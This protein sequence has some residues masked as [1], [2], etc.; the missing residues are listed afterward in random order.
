MPQAVEA[1]FRQSSASAQD[2]VVVI[3]DSGPLVA[4]VEV[5][6]TE[7]VADGVHTLHI[8]GHSEEMGAIK[9][10]SGHC[11]GFKDAQ[12]S[13]SSHATTLVDVVVGIVVGVVVVVTVVVAV[14]LVVVVVV[15]VDV[16][17]VVVGAVVVVVVVG[18][19]VVVVGDV[20]VV[21]RTGVVVVVVGSTIFIIPPMHGCSH[22]L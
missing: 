6:V 11:C 12:T 20:V 8:T 22:E 3:V 10:V 16:V 19:V 17:D 7:E 13:P 15:V 18:D 21:V 5:T 2:V 4:V 9:S 14:V 1:I